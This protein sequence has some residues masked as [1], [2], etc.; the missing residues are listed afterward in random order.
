MLQN[1]KPTSSKYNIFR[2]KSNKQKIR[3]LLVLVKHTYIYYLF[4]I[5]EEDTL[6]DSDDDDEQTPDINTTYDVCQR[7]YLKACI[8]F[9]VTPSTFWYRHLTTVKVPLQNHAIGDI[10][11]KAMATALVV[12]KAPPFSVH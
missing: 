1:N 7:I 6:L 12:R 2:R 11:V 4:C 3:K 8:L 5:S 10:G 9:K